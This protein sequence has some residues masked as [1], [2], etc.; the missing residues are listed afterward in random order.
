MARKTAQERAIEALLDHWCTAQMLAR[1]KDMALSTAKRI[2]K[3]LHKIPGYSAHM[4]VINRKNYYR[5]KPA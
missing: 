5:L 3:W 2:V 4:R 1:D